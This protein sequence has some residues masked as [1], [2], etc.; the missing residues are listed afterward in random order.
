MTMLKAEGG[1]YILALQC[2]RRVRIQ[3]GRWRSV[4]FAAGYYLYV[5]SAF[6]PGGI[7]ARV[8]RHIREDKSLRWHIDYLRNACFVQAVLLHYGDRR[9]EHDW[10]Q[11]LLCSDK[12]MP[13]DGFGCT[14]CS[15][16]SHLFYTGKEPDVSDLA[17]FLQ[18]DLLNFIP[19][20]LPGGVNDR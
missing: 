16:S 12:F 15:C 10:A 7:R 14:D 11:K 4:D 20:D 6:G 1:T 3:V 9:L 13:V 5:G 8:A 2:A 19:A 18:V 17:G